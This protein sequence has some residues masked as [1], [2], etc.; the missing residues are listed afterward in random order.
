LPAQQT[1]QTATHLSAG[2]YTVTVHCGACI[3]T[4][5]DTI[6]DLPGPSVSIITATNTTC[7]NANGG[8]VANATFGNGPYT[9]KWSNGQT[10]TNLTNVIAGPYTV[11]V[12]DVNNCTAMNSVTLTNIAGPTASITA[13]IASDCGMSDGSAT[14]TVA[15]GTQPYTFIWNSTPA[16]SSQNLTNV[17]AGN[18]CVTV[19][20]SNGC[21]I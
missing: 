14:L 13:T 11:T 10:G 6:I 20:D 12:S 17:L 15:G 18:Y 5:T 19:T 21:I 2:I 16:Q 8:A 3:A 9:Y 4:A 7:G 1:T